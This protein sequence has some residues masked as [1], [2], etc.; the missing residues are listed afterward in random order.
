MNRNIKKLIIKRM[1]DFFCK[2]N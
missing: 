2:K 1:Q